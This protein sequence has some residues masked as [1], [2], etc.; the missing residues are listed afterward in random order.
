M[1]STLIRPTVSPAMI[2]KVGRLFNGTLADILAELFQN[3]RRAGAT[4]LRVDAHSGADVTILTITD[5]GCG[6][7][8]PAS[9]VTLG[10]SGWSEAICSSEDPAGMGV[11]SLAG[12]DVAIAS[13]TAD[14]PVGWSVAIG[15][16]QWD[17]GDDLVVAEADHPPGTTISI[18]LPPEW[19][20]QLDGVIATAARHFPVPVSF[21]GSELARQ[22]WLDGAIAVS[23]WNGSR[24]GVFEG[25]DPYGARINFHGVTIKCQLPSLAQVND[26][27]L[28]TRVDIGSTPS[29]QL[30]L[31][32]RKEAVENDGLAALRA[33][34]ER[35][36][37]AVVA[38][39]PSHSLGF[40]DWQRARS[41][42]VDIP[43]AAPL[44]R[45]WQPQVADSAFSREDGPLVA[46]ESAVLAGDLEPQIAN[47][48]DRALRD[49]PL[50]QSLVQPERRYVGYA[51]YDR[52]ASIA[53][54]AF[55]V[56]AV[57]GTAYVIGLHG[58]VPELPDH[59]EARAIDMVVTV[60]SGDEVANHVVATDL[61][62]GSADNCWYDLDAARI[63]W[64][65][66]LTP[67]E[68]ADQLENA[69]FASSDDHDAD[70]WDTQHGHFQ[71][72]ARIIAMDL[73]ASPDDALV[74]RVK[75]AISDHVW[76]LPEKR[77]ITIAIVD[78]AIQVALGPEPA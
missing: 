6:I 35:A 31:P 11:F 4:M 12:R 39:Q 13:R 8:D 59:V 10:H 68:L 28:H 62:F 71:D 66:G 43:E 57:D 67:D 18:V 21:N 17:G 45:A 19:L 64:V 23:A 26:R 60:Q 1:P 70:S 7:E 9:I 29:L 34:A 15:A 3:A 56:A 50:R 48:L 42:G 37:F 2:G 72:A 25:A 47:P 58:D 36:I 41:L 44:L 49:D 75:R 24:I 77:S 33:A 14:R 54:V 78:R 32:A 30:V 40:E 5:D 65:R 16:G 74:D 52:L 46:T 63:A 55:C 27:A 22:D 53:D 20:Q 38:E 76:F 51:W 73:L 69:F 61:A